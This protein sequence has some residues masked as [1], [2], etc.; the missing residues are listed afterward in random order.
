[1]GLGLTSYRTQSFSA[2]LLIIITCSQPTDSVTI[3]FQ[4]KMLFKTLI[5]FKNTITTV[6]NLSLNTG[7]H[8]HT[9]LNM[10]AGHINLS[11]DMKM[12]ETGP[13]ISF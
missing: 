4:S 11:A 5:F 13:C 9:T 6:K 8:A 12:K 1:M 3:F 10:K 7:T 2:A